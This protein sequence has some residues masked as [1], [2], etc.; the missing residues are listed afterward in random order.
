MSAWEVTHKS[1]YLNDFIE[2]SKNLRKAVANAV[3]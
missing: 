3:A 1:A 2:L